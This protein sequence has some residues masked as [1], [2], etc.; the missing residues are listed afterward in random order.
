M[1]RATCEVIE[2]RRKERLLQETNAISKSITCALQVA[3]SD[4]SFHY[5]V[6]TEIKLFLKK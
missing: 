6:C 2:E 3:I 1:E 5:A 4:A